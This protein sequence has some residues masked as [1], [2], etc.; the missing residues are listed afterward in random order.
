MQAISDF[1]GGADGVSLLAVYHT[2]LRVSLPVLALF[3][4]V[5]SARSLLGF[6]RE[7]AVWAWLRL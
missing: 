5:R 3:V 4:V 6:R 1:I 2:L 7:P